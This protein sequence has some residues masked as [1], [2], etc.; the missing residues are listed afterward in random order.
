MSSLK[1]WNKEAKDLLVGRTIKKAVYMDAENAETLGFNQRPVVL[2]L[3]N[4]L[5]IYPSMD[6][7]GNDAGALFTTSE[8]TSCLPV[9]SMDFK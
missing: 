2:V 3:D 8:K 7:E 5:M 1:Y 4:G 6:D 9:I